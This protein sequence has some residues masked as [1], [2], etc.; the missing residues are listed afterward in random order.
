[1]SEIELGDHTAAR[2]WII[3]NQLGRRNLTPEAVSYFRGT[4]YNELKAAVKNPDGKNQHTE[5]TEVSGQNVTKPKTAERLAKELKVN[6]RT[7]I[8]DGQYAAAVDTLVEVVGE[9]VRPRLLSRDT[10]L[11]KKKTLQLATDAVEN[12][13][14]VKRA[15]DPDTNRD[16]IEQIKERSPVPFPYHVGDVC[17]II[18]KREPSL[19]KYSGCWGIILEVGEFFARVGVWDGEIEAVKPCNLSEYSFGPAQKAE[20]AK[21]RECLV[22]LQQAMANAP[23]LEATARAILSEIGKKKEP[24]LSEL[25]EKLMLTLEAVYL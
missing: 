20:V 5:A 10:P 6:S 4:L 18:A 21:I 25:E 15:L 24:Y 14:K 2:N 3:R 17:C 22:R 7:I 23:R 8:R 9:E 19:R 11:T 1:M 12:P 16:I 13:N